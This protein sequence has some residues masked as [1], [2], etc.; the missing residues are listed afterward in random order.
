MVVACRKFQMKIPLR[1]PLLTVMVRLITHNLLACHVKNCTSNNFPLGFQDVSEMEIR[2]AEFNGD[3]LRGFLPKI[4]WR[5]L[6][7]ASRQV[8]FTS[9]RLIQSSEPILVKLGDTSL[10][11]EQ[12][13]MLDDDFLRTLHHVLLEVRP[14]PLFLLSLSLLPL[15]L[16]N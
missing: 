11:M 9:L 4:E 6:V 5:A 3:F 14:L 8:R 10:P 15:K 1:R 7:D 13:E 16:F 2:Q 12:P